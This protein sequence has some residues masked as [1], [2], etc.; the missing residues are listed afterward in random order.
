MSCAGDSSRKC[1]GDWRLSLYKDA[2]TQSSPIALGCYLDSSDRTLNGISPWINGNMNVA[3]CNDYC[4]QR[5]FN[6]AGVQYGNEVSLETLARAWSEAQV[7]DWQRGAPFSLLMIHSAIVAR[8]PQRPAAR[9]Q[10]P[11]ATCAA[12][13][14]ALIRVAAR[15][16]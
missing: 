1:G 14:V 4:G 2:A 16:V 11:N 5:G 8:Q 12:P 3:L 15:G 6:Y 10:T 9:S 13:A 7:V